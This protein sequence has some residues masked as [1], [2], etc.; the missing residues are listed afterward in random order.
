LQNSGGNHA[1][2]PRNES[3]IARHRGSVSTDRLCWRRAG[4][5]FDPRI[6]SAGGA[7]IWGWG[8][9]K[10]IG[11]HCASFSLLFFAD[12]A[13]SVI[14]NDAVARSFCALARRA[15]DKF[16]PARRL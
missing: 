5:T 11:S 2:L 16:N 15:R 9:K 14:E 12:D 3:S 1:V 13:A 7:E 6:E 4:E 8:E 10:G